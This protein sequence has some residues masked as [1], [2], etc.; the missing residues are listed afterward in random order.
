MTPRPGIF[1]FVVGPSGVGKD[2][3]I[4]GAR[5][6]LGTGG[7]YVFARRVITRPADAGGEAHEA[8]SAAEFAAREG[9]GGFLVAWRAHG[10]RYGLPADLLDDIAAGRHVVANGSRT[11]VAALS[12][13]VPRFALV[14]VAAGRDVRA[15]RIA[16]R[17]RESG[18]AVAARLDREVRA[19]V[20]PGVAVLEVANYGG[21]A[22]GVAR[23]VAALAGAASG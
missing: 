15:G 11:V 2:T 8:A 14:S 12:A 6:A 13:R 18:A 17:G 16:A 10:L 1:F 9:A 19:L 21:I 7:R 22:D 5:A 3:L 23:F 4:D 20:P